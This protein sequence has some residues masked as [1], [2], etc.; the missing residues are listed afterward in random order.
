MTSPAA[1]ALNL[2]KSNVFRLLVTITALLS[3]VIALGAGSTSMLQNLYNDWHLNRT[4]TLTIYLPPESNPEEV[5][6]L[7]HSLSSL[8]DI[9]KVSP[10]TTDTLKQWLKP[11]LTQPDALPLPMVLEIQLAPQANREQLTKHIQQS[12]PTAEVDDSLPLLAQVEH[13]VTNLQF[14]ALILA[15]TMLSIMALLIVLTVRTG[16]N[17]HQHVLH[18]LITLGAT[19]SFITRTVTNQVAVRVL[20]GTLIGA[21]AA[22]TMLGAGIALSPTLAGFVTPLT[23]AVLLVSCLSLPLLSALTAALTTRQILRRI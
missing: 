23:F 16:L 17:A 1:R 9:T 4:Q 11:L 22:A 10:I 13:T 15:A 8:S 2:K 21:A 18:L 19:D 14:A 3:W 20:N 12:F 5:Q 7:Q 6:Q